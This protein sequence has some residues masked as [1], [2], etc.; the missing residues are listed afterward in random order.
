[1]QTWMI[2]LSFFD[3]NSVRL[4]QSQPG[5]RWKWFPPDYDEWPWWC[6]YQC[7]TLFR[8]AEDAFQLVQ[9]NPFNFIDSLGPPKEVSLQC[10]ME[11]IKITLL[12]L[13]L[14]QKDEL[15]IRLS[16]VPRDDGGQREQ[17]KSTEDKVRLSSSRN[18]QSSLVELLTSLVDTF[19]SC[20]AFTFR[21]KRQSE[22][23][24]QF[25][26]LV[27]VT[28]FKQAL[29]YLGRLQNEF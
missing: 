18:L 26:S 24:R 25:L 28:F 5:E 21:W 14:N 15:L 29:E 16:F 27:V 19:L 11:M 9:A 6:F 1:M 22:L 13:Q 23:V 20:E 10:S 12:I 4:N 8:V 17:A 7:S 3:S 2:F